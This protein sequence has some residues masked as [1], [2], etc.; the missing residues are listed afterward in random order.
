MYFKKIMQKLSECK[1]KTKN[2]WADFCFLPN[3]LFHNDPTKW[4]TGEH[5]LLQNT[6]PGVNKQYC[7]LCSALCCG[8]SPGLTLE[9][10][11]RWLQAL[12]YTLP[13]SK[14]W[15]RSSDQNTSTQTWICV[16]LKPF[17][18]LFPLT[19][20]LNPK[21]LLSILSHRKAGSASNDQKEKINEQKFLTHK[22]T[23]LTPCLHVIC[24]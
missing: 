17:G 10:L 18:T 12:P 7:F 5:S 23:T 2:H 24:L 21:Y 9:A 22:D 16:L 11:Y 14:D 15:L 4:K 20:I 1:D 13:S 8:R 6:F 19:M 3:I